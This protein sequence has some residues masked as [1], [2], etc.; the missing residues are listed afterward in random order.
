M[1]IEN[2]QLKKWKKQSLTREEN[3]SNVRFLILNNVQLSKVFQEEAVVA[4]GEKGLGRHWAGGEVIGQDVT[5]YHPDVKWGYISVRLFLIEI[6][7]WMSTF[8]LLKDKQE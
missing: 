2:K 7:S 5:N 6:G 8:F 1:N 4:E 3:R